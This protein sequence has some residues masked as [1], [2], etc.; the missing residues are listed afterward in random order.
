[1]TIA[2]R[3]EAEPDLAPRLEAA[4]PVPPV[5][6]GE[7]EPRWGMPALVTAGL[8]VLL[9]GF[10]LLQT[11]NFVTDQFARAPAL[12]W[13]TLGLAV[14]GFGLIGLGFWR[15]ARGLAALHG[16]DRLRR[17]LASGEGRRIHAAARIWL[18]VLPEGAA[19]RPAI[20]AANDPDAILALLRAG[21]SADLRA[22]ADG[23]GRAAAVQ[24][25]AGM[26]AAPA[27]ALVVLLVS[28]RGLRL[29]RQV[30]ALHGLRPGWFATLGLLRRTVLA[31]STAAVTEIAANTAA[32][33][34]LSNPLLAHLI[35][36]MAGAG[37]AARRMLV[38]ARAAAV[39]CNPLPPE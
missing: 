27:P 33:A 2:P 10:A 34:L 24:V 3:I 31:A 22:R 30:A 4:L 26:A 1:M 32:H 29:I 8:S 16:I 36:E 13:A 28:W 38:L 12:G 18:G 6:S 39:A 9:F 19:L 11:G 15:E 23:L 20:D 17:D 35:G 7:T 5:L 21:P 37:V 25:V 14:I